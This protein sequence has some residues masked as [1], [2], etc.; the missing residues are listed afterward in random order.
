[1]PSSAFLPSSSSQQQERLVDC[2]SI[3][4][5]Q[6]SCSQE[7]CNLAILGPDLL[8][9]WGQAHLS[10]PGV[11]AHLQSPTWLT[12]MGPSGSDP[13]PWSEMEDMTVKVPYLTV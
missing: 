1:M 3:S 12:S 4:E 13:P 11:P 9:T 2:D 6:H 5:F 7:P 10:A 8:P